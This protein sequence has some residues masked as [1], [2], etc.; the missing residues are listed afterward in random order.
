MWLLESGGWKTGGPAILHAYNATNIAVELYNSSQAGTR[1][2]LGPAIKFTVPTIAMERCMRA[3][4]NALAILGSLTTTIYYQVSGTVS[5][6]V[7]SGVG[8]TATGGVSCTYSDATGHYACTVPQG[9]SGTVTPALSGY[10]FAPT[11]RTYANVAADQPGQDYVASSVTGT[12]VWVEDAV[13]AGG[14]RRRQTRAG[15]G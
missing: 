7:A 2:T 5:G 12:T 1:D 11:S 3:T 15:T 9:W 6:A 14:H 4:G 8:F 13:P 10:T